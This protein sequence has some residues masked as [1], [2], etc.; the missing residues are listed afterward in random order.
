MNKYNFCDTPT[1]ASDGICSG[2]GFTPCRSVASKK[3]ETVAKCDCGNKVLCDSFTNTCDK[4]GADFA[5][6]GGK[7]APREQWGFET[8]ETASDILIG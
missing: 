2:C 8:G 4:C 3:N 6:D 1:Y 7:L 5:I